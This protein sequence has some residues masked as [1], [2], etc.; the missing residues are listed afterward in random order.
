MTPFQ[1]SYLLKAFT[2]KESHILRYW[3]IRAS[4]RGWGGVG[5][6]QHRTG[7]CPVAQGRDDKG[8]M[9]PGA[10]GTGWEEREMGR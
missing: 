3:G 4:I 9:S 1:L 6:I 5:I 8:R 10:A 2:S 7:G